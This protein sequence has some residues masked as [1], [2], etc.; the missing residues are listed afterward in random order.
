MTKTPG[1]LCSG[2]E[3]DPLVSFLALCGSGAGLSQDVLMARLPLTLV[4]LLRIFWLQLAWLWD[5]IVV[6]FLQ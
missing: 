5:R 6:N 1:P 2:L 4:C 3:L